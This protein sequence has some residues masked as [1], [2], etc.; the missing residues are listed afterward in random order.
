M[1]TIDQWAHFLPSSI[2]TPWD[3]IFQSTVY[4]MV[5][6]LRVLRGRR[7][8]CDWV[9]ARKTNSLLEAWPSSVLLGGRGPLLCLCLHRTSDCE[10]EQRKGY[11]EFTCIW[12]LTLESLPATVY[13]RL[14]RQFHGQ[15]L[16]LLLEH[17][18]GPIWSS[19]EL[20]FQAEE[21]SGIFIVLSFF[22]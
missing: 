2:P 10:T 15:P 5:S 6:L 4:I 16:L 20:I 19:T 1:H 11:R 17:E 8:S 7:D 12:Q 21:A 14:S 18:S 13:L 22:F 3:T 9:W